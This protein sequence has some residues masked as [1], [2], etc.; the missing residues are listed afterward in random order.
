[1]RRS[2]L[3]ASVEQAAPSLHAAFERV[4]RKLQ[5][6]WRQQEEYRA[7]IE[8]VRLLGLSQGSPVLVAPTSLARDW[9]KAHA[10]HLIEEFLSERVTLEGPL[11]IV[12]DQD[13]PDGAR[14]LFQPGM[15]VSPLRAEPQPIEAAPTA[16]A[17]QFETFCVN[18]GNRAAYML[19]RDVAEGAAR[20]FPLIL[21]HG[22]P[23]VGKS[24][25]MNAA[26]HVALFGS[27]PPRRVR[28][29]MA[30]IFIEEFQ[31]ALHKH[32]DKDMASFKALVR[33]NDL[34][35]LDDVHRIAGKRATEEE[36]LDTIAVILS[37]GGQ[38]VVSADHGPQGLSGFD[39][40]VRTQLKGA[41]DVAIP[42]PDFEL[43]RA[44][45]DSRVAAYRQTNPD[46]DVP[47]AALD[48]MAGRIVSSG[49]ELD[50]AVRQLLMASR[51]G[52]AITVA[53]AEAI[54]RAKFSEPEK[55]PTVD[56]V[57][58]TTAKYYGLTVQEILSRTRQKAIA[59][60]R[61]VAMYLC[62]KLTTRSL[63]DLGRR[64]AA[65]GDKKFDHTTVLYARDRI[66]ELLQADPTLAHDVEEI[67]RLIREQL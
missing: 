3:I 61:Q 5:D 56:L 21:L 32:K 24:H 39:E 10:A 30:Q 57:I 33:E 48:L 14:G 12:T 58:R 55:R 63:P 8:P 41:T 27:G 7:W 2:V 26:S 11:L 28:Y 31:G 62:C 13:V 35:L 1:M 4:R 43:R 53:A 20:D 46:F 40:R 64:F 34:F 66:V 38:V 54:L 22:P 60:P 67:T 25:L 59:R 17:Q 18:A 9:I 50:G 15:Q 23:G 42:L 44:I 49:R 16:S 6:D 19:M 47:S 51:S 29:M 65:A 45:L 52:Q 36:F 37:A